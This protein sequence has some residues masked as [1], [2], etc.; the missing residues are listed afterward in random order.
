VQ[1]FVFAKMS[2]ADWRL[3]TDCKTVG[4]WNLHS[5]L[6]EDLDFFLLLSSASGIAGLHGQANYA[7]GNTYMDA[8]AHHRVSR[9]LR[10]TSLDLGALME[11]GLL[12]E[13]PD[14]LKRVL[15]Y[16]ALN[17]ISRRYFHAI[18]DYYLDPSTPVDPQAIIGLRTSEDSAIITS[19]RPL[20]SKLRAT[21]SSPSVQAQDHDWRSVLA[22][23]AANDLPA[24]VAD[25]LVRKLSKTLSS[26]DGEID[27]HKPL[28]A[29]G[30]DSLLSVELRSW[31]K[32]TFGAEVALFEIQGGIG[33]EGLARVVIEKCKL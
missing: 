24:L 29:Y 15:S 19:R 8:L 5:V 7:A 32:A 27:M 2:Y 12:A 23:P 4:S 1:D 10:A 6:P 16:G 20:F 30:I 28:A 11:D 14:F 26:L 18:L 3:G 9:G 31:I 22:D 21:T 33:F 25:A 13:D 17:G